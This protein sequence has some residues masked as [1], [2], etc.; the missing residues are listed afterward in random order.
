MINPE[1]WIDPS[2]NRIVLK[3]ILLFVFLYL[4]WGNVNTAPRNSAG[5]GQAFLPVLLAA[6]FLP[7]GY[8]LLR[9][10]KYS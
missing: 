8:Y 1:C 10:R 9:L 6:I 4:V 5:L 2:S 7:L 3:M